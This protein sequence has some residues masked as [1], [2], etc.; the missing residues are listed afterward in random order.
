MLLEK[1]IETN[2]LNKVEELRNYMRKDK[3]VLDM[4][5]SLF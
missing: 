3:I 4:V 1:L 5:I 2:N